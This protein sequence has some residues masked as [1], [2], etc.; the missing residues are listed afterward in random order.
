[1]CRIYNSICEDSKYECDFIFRGCGYNEA[2][3]I[4]RES[5]CDFQNINDIKCFGSNK[6]CLI[7]IINSHHYD[8]IHYFDTSG[9]NLALQILSRFWGIPTVFSICNALDAYG[10]SSKT[11]L[12]KLKLQANL[13]SVIDL[14]Y[15]SGLA[16]FKASAFINKIRI[17]PG[18]FT[19]LSVFYPYKKRKLMVYAAARLNTR[20]NPGLLVDAINICQEAIREHGYVI[21]ILGIGDEQA[22]LENKINKYKLQDLVLLEGFK[23][24]SD[25]FPYAKVAF[26]LQKKENYPSQCVAEACASGCYLIVTDVG[27]S[28]KCASEL[29]ACFVND[30]ASN[31]SQAIVEYLNKTEEEQSVIEFEARKYAMANYSIEKSKSYYIEVLNNAKER[32][33]NGIQTL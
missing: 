16:T 27:D 18:S 30:D 33:K 21:S 29:F 19:D 32:H 20:K 28:R 7:S 4:L 11:T 3:T 2:I 5:N 31:L 23:K 25:Y 17:T 8:V 9:F 26:S 22:N 14:L 13:S 24:S 6:A 10:I 15:P 1:M 12:H